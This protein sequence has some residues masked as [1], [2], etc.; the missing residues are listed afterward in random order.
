M[1][2]LREHVNRVRLSADR[3]FHTLI[4]MTRDVNHRYRQ[5]QLRHLLG[6][7]TVAA[8]LC[9]V[10]APHI[11]A[12]DRDAQ[13]FT[14]VKSLIVAVA[15][16]G[17]T[18]FLI[19]KREK[20]EDIAGPQ[21]ARFERRQ[22]RIWSWVIGGLLVVS[23][24]GTIWAEPV[25]SLDVDIVPGSPVLLFFAVNYLVIRIC[26]RIDPFGLDARS[27][28]LIMGGLQFHRWDD[29]GRYSWSGAQ[30]CQLNLFLKR[31]TVL[32]FRADASF[33]ERLDQILVEHIPK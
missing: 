28:G 21:L 13:V 15:V 29:I 30:A 23:Y 20:L 8:V 33:V 22:S 10:L 3:H 26:W 17:I 14:L 9:A 1:L 6:L 31:R 2:T 11:R 4:D 24:L 16:I 32:H 19:V 5:Y 18:G 7:L 12:M 27:H 25:K